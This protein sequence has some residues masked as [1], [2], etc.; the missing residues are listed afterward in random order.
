MFLLLFWRNARV[1][2]IRRAMKVLVA[3]GCSADLWTW[4]QTE[5]SHRFVGCL[6][7]SQTLFPISQC[8]GL[9]Q[10]QRQQLRSTEP[11]AEHQWSYKY[12]A[13]LNVAT[14]RAENQSNIN[15][16]I[17]SHM[18]N[19]TV[20]NVLYHDGLF[21]SQSIWITHTNC[22]LTHGSSFKAGIYLHLAGSG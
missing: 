21:S 11:Q 6:K 12:F 10:W 3:R 9:F 4:V 8:K 17:N 16:K 1:E 22:M 15:E 14:I 18:L 5:L 13:Q 2:I 7:F 19:I 20:E